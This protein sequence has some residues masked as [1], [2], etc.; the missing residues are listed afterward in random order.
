METLVSVCM[1]T[2]N[3]EKYIAQAI[4]SVLM[5]RTNF[6]FEIV[7]G[8]DCST[9]RTREIVLEY[10][11]KY[12]DKIKLLLQEKNVGMMQN[13]ID[14]FNACKGKYIAL[15]EGDDYWTDQYKLKKQVDILEAHPEYSMCFTA[16]NVVDSDNKF[17]REEHYPD[18]I[19][20]TKDVVEGFIPS[21]QTIVL[22]NYQDLHKF[23]YQNHNH[24]SGDRLV[25]YYCSL[26]GPIYYIDEVTACYRE[27]GEGVW[28][29][30]DYWQKR[31]KRFERFKKFY[32][33][34]GIE[35]NNLNLI[36]RGFYEFYSRVLANIK[37]PI[38]TIKDLKK[39]YKVYLY[40]SPI[41][42]ILVIIYFRFKK[43]ILKLFMAK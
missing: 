7:I 39:F 14:T 22:R 34:L 30:F 31:E 42:L 23:L 9:D 32:T 10:K 21:T 43:R 17:L 20:T 15:L 24:P 33:I 2:Y 11:A 13:F 4:D 3:H 35:N 25:A 41:P 1:I 16:R 18:K 36:D 12:P 38:K 19:Y 29:S 28:S 37:H 27:S 8:E 6:D 5:Q 26:M 40:K